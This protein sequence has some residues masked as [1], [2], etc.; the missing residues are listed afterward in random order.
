MRLS[1]AF[2]WSR[3]AARGIIRGAALVIFLLATLSVPVGFGLLRHMETE[4]VWKT[5]EE[6][7]TASLRGSAEEMEA[8]ARKAFEATDAVLAGWKLMLRD[9]T[10]VFAAFWVLS[11]VVFWAGGLGSE[12]VHH[13][14]PAKA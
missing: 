12:S 2:P 13:V 4:L 10:W 5:R 8:L 11:V 1:L 7:R 6:I 14:M 3:A 9:L